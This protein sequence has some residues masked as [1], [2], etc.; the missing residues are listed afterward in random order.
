[1]NTRLGINLGS[2]YCVNRVGGLRWNRVHGAVLIFG[3]T[4]FKEFSNIW[5]A[6][7]FL[8]PGL[9]IREGFGG[10]A[11]FREKNTRGELGGGFKAISREE[12]GDDVVFSGEVID[13]EVGLREGFPPSAEAPIMRFKEVRGKHELGEVPMVGVNLD[14]KLGLRE[15]VS[16]MGEGVDDGV[17][18]LVGTIP[19][20]FAVLKLMVE[21]KKRMPTIFVFLFHHASIGNI[22]GVGREAN[23]FFRI[24]SSEEDVIPDG[25]EEGLKGF[26]LESSFGPGP[27]DV[28]FEEIVKAGD[29]VGVMGNEFVV[30]AK[31]TEDMA[32]V[33]NSSGFFEV[34]ER[35]DLVGGHTNSFS[36]DNI[37]TKEV[38]FFPEPLAFVGLEAEFIFP[39][40]CEDLRDLLLMFFKRSF[41]KDDDIVQVGV[42]EDAEKRV[43]DRVNEALEDRRS[44]GKSHWH[45][46]VFVEAVEGFEGGFGFVSGCDAEVCESGTDVKGGD[47]VGGGEV[48]HD[49]SGER[50]RVL[51]EFN[52]AVE[53]SVV[54]N[55]A[56]LSGA[57]SV[58]GVAYEEDGGRGVG[59]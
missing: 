23:G 22:G 7:R 33:I 41:G 5:C 44:S 58:R 2:A 3:K 36:T 34:S 50:N 59:F 17:E 19:I 21:E 46:G 51:V 8:E 25:L 6:S 53:V 20:L 32:K 29:S 38:Y 13:H 15:E 30:E 31:H 49:G 35:L 18:F 52:L 4:L 11:F 45:D 48:I 56:E 14:G 37:K 55:K 42:A 39:E 1:M 10:E 43:E 24:E 28:L 54:D 12:V 47:P 27:R 26:L 57:V 9:N 40:G 16:V